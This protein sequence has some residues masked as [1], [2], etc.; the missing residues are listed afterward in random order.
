MGWNKIKGVGIRCLPLKTLGWSVSV[1]YFLGCSS[2]I[3]HVHNK[4]DHGHGQP[5]MGCVVGPVLAHS[6][7]YVTNRYTCLRSLRD[8]N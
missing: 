2:E 6:A 4:T 1:C 3:N 5:I 7:N 8:N